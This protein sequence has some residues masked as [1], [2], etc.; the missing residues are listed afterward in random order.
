MGS[1]NFGLGPAAGQYSA[2]DDNQ[3]Q[4]ADSL[5]DRGVD[6]VLDE[7][8]SPPERP[9]ARS[10]FGPL[11]TVDQRLAEEELD[12]FSRIGNPLDRDEQQRSDDAERESE[13]PQRREVGQQRAGRLMGPDK[14]IGEHRESQLVAEDVGISGGAASAE[15][16]AVYIID[17]TD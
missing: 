8:Y 6:D 12:P 17:S 3:L 10:A 5:I 16:A 2:D 15:E 11:E 13:F 1:R 4:P 9:Y 7:G 14:G